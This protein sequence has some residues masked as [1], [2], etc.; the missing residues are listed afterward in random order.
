MSDQQSTLQRAKAAIDGTSPD[1][2]TTVEIAILDATWN[3]EY[4]LT[5][6]HQ[7]LKSV[8]SSIEREAEYLDVHSTSN[9]LGVLQSNAVNVDR[10]AALI[11]AAK[12]QLSNL[13]GILRRE[14][15]CHLVEVHGVEDLDSEATIA[16]LDALH[17]RYHED[18]VV[19]GEEN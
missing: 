9:E 13:L 18:A 5:Q 17:K 16:I 1:D 6:Q 7:N 14:R 12:K 8:R 3:L 11:G 15:V 10:T 2:M 4:L 19:R